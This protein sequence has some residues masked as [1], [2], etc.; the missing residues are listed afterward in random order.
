M[1]QEPATRARDA[2]LRPQCPSGEGRGGQEREARPCQ[3]S[4]RGRQGLRGDAG[5]QDN[6]QARREG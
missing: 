4:K 1:I 5:A 3:G 2:E 6:E